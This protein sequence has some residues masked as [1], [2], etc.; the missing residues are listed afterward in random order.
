MLLPLIIILF[1]SLW[2]PAL[3]QQQFFHLVGPSAVFGFNNLNGATALECKRFFE[4][5]TGELTIELINV[6]NGS[7]C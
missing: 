4:N 1:T 7:R 2:H 6:F 5:I 3:G